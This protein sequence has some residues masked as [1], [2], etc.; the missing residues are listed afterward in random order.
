MTLQ[1]VSPIDH[2]PLYLVSDPCRPVLVLPEHVLDERAHVERVEPALVP[3]SHRSKQHRLLLPTLSEYLRQLLRC[4]RGRFE[5]P[6]PLLLAAVTGD[7]LG[8]RDYKVRAHAT[9]KLVVLTHVHL[10]VEVEHEVLLVVEPA[11]P[12]LVRR[13]GEGGQPQQFVLEAEE[14]LEH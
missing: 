6:L 2:K 3:E 7:L 14:S 11:R 12:L 9:R 8:R 10:R 5:C 13:V 1:E 4:L